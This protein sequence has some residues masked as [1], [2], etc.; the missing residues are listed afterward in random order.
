[1]QTV[2]II[3]M[4]EIGRRMGK[5]LLAASHPMIGY[6]IRREALERPKQSRFVL[7]ENTADLCRQADIV[8][9][10]LTDGAALRAVARGP[11][12]MAANLAAGKPYVD[13]V[14][15]AAI[16]RFC[17]TADSRTLLDLTAE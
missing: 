4:G 16:G 9:S 1:M 12:G 11:G 14:L 8:L 10:C 3:R 7:A 2:R 17:G 5:L 6:D 13:T 15:A